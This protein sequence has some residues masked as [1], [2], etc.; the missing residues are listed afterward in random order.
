MIFN[1]IESE[2]IK[3]GID[4]IIFHKVLVSDI[5]RL[6][7][8]SDILTELNR[9]DIYIEVCDN[10]PEICSRIE[11]NSEEQFNLLVA[12]LMEHNINMNFVT[13]N[14]LEEK[15]V[16]ELLDKIRTSLTKHIYMAT[17][18]KTKKKYIVLAKDISD[19][20]E[21]LI[22]SS[23]DILEDVI[24]KNMDIVESQIFRIV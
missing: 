8:L 21:I 24:F 3:Q 17:D 11:F 18:I 10:I 16:D 6:K 12:Y 20:Y 4:R 14:Q 5:D 15:L 22:E 1:F 9:K 7:D 19:A 13:S 2:V 23:P